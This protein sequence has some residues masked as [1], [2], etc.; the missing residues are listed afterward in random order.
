MQQFV[1]LARFL[2]YVFLTN[3][4]ESITQATPLPSSLVPVGSVRTTRP[5][6]WITT[7]SC[8]P[9]TSGGSVISNSTGEP[10]SSDASALKELQVILHPTF[11]QLFNIDRAIYLMARK[12]IL[13]NFKILEVGIFSVDVEPDA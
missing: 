3:S 13:K 7:F 12:N 2:D 11:H 8:P 4:Y 6:H 10:I 5:L 1:R 9:V